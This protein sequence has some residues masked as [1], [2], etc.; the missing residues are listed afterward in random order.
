MFPAPT[1]LKQ[2]DHSIVQLVLNGGL[3]S[4]LIKFTLFNRSSFE[5][6][7]EFFIFPQGTTQLAH[8]A[9]GF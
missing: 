1:D 7:F 5:L 6:H 3:Y 4:S 2:Q 8:N 9:G